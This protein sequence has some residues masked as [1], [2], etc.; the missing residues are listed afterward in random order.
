MRG[1]LLFVVGLATGYVLGSRAGRERY[2]QIKAG[3][4]KVWMSQPVQAGVTQI[5]GF[6]SQ[7]IDSLSGKVADQVRKVLGTV[8]GVTRT[9]TIVATKSTVNDAGT[10]GGSTSPATP[11]ATPDPAV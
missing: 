5:K 2:E 4:D 7:R 10:T 6:A 3:A 8:L 11:P 1:K 9:T